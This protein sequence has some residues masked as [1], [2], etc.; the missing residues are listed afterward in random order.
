MHDLPARW[1]LLADAVVV[2]SGAAALAAAVSASAGAARVAVLERSETFGG[3]TAVS[4]GVAWVPNNHPRRS[5]PARP[6]GA[7]S[8][9]G[10]QARRSDS[11]RLALCK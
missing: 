10:C 9:A 1:D 11:G 2:G 6:A 5:G 4:G 3:T 7:A 8:L